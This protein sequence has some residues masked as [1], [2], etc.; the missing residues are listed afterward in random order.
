MRSKHF[1]P[2]RRFGQHHVCLQPSDALLRL[3]VL[4]LQPIIVFLR[5]NHVQRQFLN[6][7]QQLR[8]HLAQPDA[9]RLYFRLGWDIRQMVVRLIYVSSSLEDASR[10][11]G[12][13]T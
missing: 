5:L 10:Q 4:R 9:V 11:P 1:R 6:L 12:P 2:L 3:T 7:G 8:L 13:N